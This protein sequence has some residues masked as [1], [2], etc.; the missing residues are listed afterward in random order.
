MPVIFPFGEGETDKIV[1]EFLVDKWFRSYSFRN[2][3]SVGGKS[4]FNNK[5][6]E[7]VEGDLS[8]G[9]DEVRILVFRD[10][11][12]GEKIE[13]IVRSFQN[14]VWRLLTCWELKPDVEPLIENTIY[15]WEA[16]ANTDFAGLRFVLHIANIDIPVTLQNQTTD[17]YILKVALTEQ[18]LNRFARET[19]VKSSYE[20]L[21]DLIID[22]IP[23]V[24]NEKGISFDED[25]DY[26]SAYLTATRFWVVK[27]TEE[28]ARLV[29]IILDRAL[30]YDKE[31]F[32]RVFKSWRIAIEEVIR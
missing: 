22:R 13:D 32:N 25:K 17:G 31:G 11:D 30:K 10:L 2:F 18:V 28:K 9:R 15:R 3:V 24:V 8:A 4:H 14:I 19:K 16:P 12:N 5:I 1:F 26:L 20:V 7:T 27:H 21:F 6:S 29:K 23:Y